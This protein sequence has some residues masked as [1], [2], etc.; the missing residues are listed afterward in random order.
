MSVNVR[1]APSPTG[2]LHIGNIRAALFNWLFARKNGGKFMLRLDDTDQE[3]STPQFA[4]AIERDLGWL[5]LNWD[6]FARESDRYARYQEV[7]DI[8]VKKGRAYACY[9]TAEEL[10]LKRKIRL[11]QGR[12]PVYD[13]AALKL[14]DAEKQKYQQEGRT[15]HW[16][17]LLRDED[18]AWD[19]LIQGHKNFP[20]GAV[21]DPVIMRADGVP[22]YTYCSVVDDIDY[23]ITHIIR[24]EDH[25]TNTCVQIQIWKAITDA[26]PPH[27]AHFPLLVSAD[28][29][30][31]SKRLGTLSIASMRDEMGLEAMGINS[32]LA[33]LG[34]SQPVE[35]HKNLADLVANFDLANVSR[36]TP[37][38]S[39]ADIETLSGKILQ[40]TD[41]ADVHARFVTLGMKEASEHFWHTVR[42]N[43]NTLKDAQKWYD[44][45]YGAP[46]TTVTD[47]GFIATAQQLLPAL[48]WHD[49]T[50]SDWT[51]KIKEQ[52]GRKGK[53]LFMPLRLALT[54]AE[55]GPEM[56]HMLL[57][58]GR[59][60]VL[61]RLSGG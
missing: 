45:I 38:F 36:A 51:N 12:P 20:A 19:D 61:S 58:L 54:G 50:W 17:F 47:Q 34:T 37:K 46:A 25:V 23:A 28:G 57:L 13:R 11:G 44:V 42:G 26:P 3:R 10:D 33:C 8:L 2:L 39:I 55:H 56:A 41:F 24:G 32:L 40:Q 14:S 7:L 5:G 52:T 18:T 35:A 30:E 59:D 27:F 6:V 29:T 1:I 21:S 9:E 15:P 43:I 53:D 22:L 31:M 49:K 4:A 48:P 60:K 16:R